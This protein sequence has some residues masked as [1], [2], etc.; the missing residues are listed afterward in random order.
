ML[1]SYTLVKEL[2]EALGLLAAAPF[3]YVSP[4]GAAVGLEL[5]NS[6]RRP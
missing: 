5:N 4:A 6:D 1:N 2:Q 3:K